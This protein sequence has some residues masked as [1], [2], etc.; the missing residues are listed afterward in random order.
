MEDT[1]EVRREECA[2]GTAGS[3][4]IDEVIPEDPFEKEHC[5]YRDGRAQIPTEDNSSRYQWDIYRILGQ[6]SFRRI[7]VRSC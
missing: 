5:T 6:R 2:E 4:H 3:L 1:C 7:K